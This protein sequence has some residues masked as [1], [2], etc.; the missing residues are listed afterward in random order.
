[1]ERSCGPMNKNP[2]EGV[3]DQGERA[4]NRE[5][6][7]IDGKRRKSGGG[8]LKECV[9]TWGDVVSYARKGN[10]LSRSEKSA[11][12]VVVGGEAVK[13]SDRAKGRTRGSVQHHAD[14]ASIASDAASVW[15][16]EIGES[17]ERSEVAEALEASP[18]V[19][20]KSVEEASRSAWQGKVRRV[21]VPG[22]WLRRCGG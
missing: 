13:P 20:D 2:A 8:A 11:E 16:R 19:V 18:I 4:S 1:M 14:V 10:G 12:V 5:A 6:L 17:I 15:S 9:L 22:R 3:A 21:W 7:V